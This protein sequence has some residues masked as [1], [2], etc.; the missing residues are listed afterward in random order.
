[1]KRIAVTAA[2]SAALVLGSMGG[3]LAAGMTGSGSAGSWTHPRSSM[4]T[5]GSMQN[6]YSG[7]SEPG[8]PMAGVSGDRYTHA[9]NLLEANG[10]TGIENFAHN[11]QTFTATAMHNGKRVPV[12][13]EPSGQIRL[14][15]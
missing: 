10:Y 15:G 8:S 5:Q 7:S 1:M 6:G 4:Q 9:L 12:T 3:A 11:G 13:V 14:Q 2:A